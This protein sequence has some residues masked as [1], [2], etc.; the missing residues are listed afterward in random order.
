M[1]VI[2][3]LLHIDL[4]MTYF[5]LVLLF[6]LLGLCNFTGYV[7]N[8]AVRLVVMCGL[9][10]CTGF[11]AGFLSADNDEE[12]ITFSY[13]YEKAPWLLF[14]LAGTAVLMFAVGLVYSVGVSRRKWVRE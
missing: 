9:F 11:A 13:L 4:G 6:V 12:G 5:G 10:A 3:T 7:R 8:I 2:F 14:V 1:C